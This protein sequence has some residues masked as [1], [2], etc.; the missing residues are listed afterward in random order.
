[1]DGDNESHR[2]RDAGTNT[3]ELLVLQVSGRIIRSH[4]KE[5]SDAGIWNSGPALMPAFWWGSRLLRIGFKLCM[6]I[7]LSNSCRT[8][9][10]KYNLYA[11]ANALGI[12]AAIR[13]VPLHD[14]HYRA[15]E[16]R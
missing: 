13:P 16:L 10:I 3:L 2:H 15:S 5:S 7:T 9:H 1:M 8:M 11:F 6:A 14:K 4:C 12:S